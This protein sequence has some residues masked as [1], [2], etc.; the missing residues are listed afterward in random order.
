LLPPE[1]TITNISVGLST[2]GWTTT[3][4]D[5]QGNPV[6]VPPKQMTPLFPLQVI[7]HSDQ[8]Q[9]RLPIDPC[10]RFDY[11]AVAIDTSGDEHPI[12]T[13]APRFTG[14]I[15]PDSIA[16]VFSFDLPVEKVASFQLSVRH[17]RHFMIFRHV[18][19]RAGVNTAPLAQTSV[20]LCEA[21]KALYDTDYLQMLSQ[22]AT[23][24]ESNDLDAA[25]KSFTAFAAAT[26]KRC[27][28]LDGTTTAYLVP[29]GEPV[30]DQINS[31]LQT[32]DRDTALR[33]LNAETP[34]GNNLWQLTH[35]L[36]LVVPVTSLQ[37]P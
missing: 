23:A 8:C 7:N 18:S 31:A 5:P 13:D 1:E 26:H 33:L 35:Q 11:Q 21:D 15:A 17:T 30:L 25:Q 20:A 16:R 9:L 37:Y 4:L 32:G 19:L 2:G 34:A 27:L 14:T 28:A 22:V 6:G 10:M 29:L 24:L 3:T 36:A 12:L